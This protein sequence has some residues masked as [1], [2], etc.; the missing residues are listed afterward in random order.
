MKKKTIFVLLLILV[1]TAS[2]FMTAC[3]KS[4]SKS[5]SGGETAESNTLE[6][7]AVS[8]PDV[9]KSIDEAM[10]ESDVEVEIRG[11]DVIYSFE[12]SK[13]EG[14]TEDVA[15][16]PDVVE[17]LQKALDNAG[18]TFGG[19]ART[20]EKATDIKG[21][22]VVVKY[23]YD[24]EELATQTFDSSDAAAEDESKEGESEDK[25]SSEEQDSDSE[26]DSGSDSDSDSETGSGE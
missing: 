13:M 12:L 14:Y 21:I 1:M 8:N 19:I 22:R 3:S 5:K 20:L 10:S 23:T 4:S 9:Q 2:V 6:Q 24:G 25:D 11:N 16:D 15:T 18:P 26:G 7:Y 17:S